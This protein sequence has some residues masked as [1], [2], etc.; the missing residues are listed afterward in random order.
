MD[1]EKKHT[2]QSVTVGMPEIKMVLVHAGNDA[3]NAVANSIFV[4]KTKEQ[5]DKE[6]AVRKIIEHLKLDL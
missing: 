4:N 3:Q 6:Q 5:L 1:E 2:Y